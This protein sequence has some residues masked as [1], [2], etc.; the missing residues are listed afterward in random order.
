M[1]SYLSTSRDCGYDA[2][3]T[4]LHLKTCEKKNK[5]TEFPAEQWSGVDG[6]FCQIIVVI[7]TRNSA[8]AKGPHNVPCQLKLCKMLHKCLSSAFDM[9]C[10]RS[11]KVIQSHMIFPVRDV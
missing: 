3:I 4:K 6:N 8:I 7:F 9:S 1:M 11:F 10:N 5:N 2:K